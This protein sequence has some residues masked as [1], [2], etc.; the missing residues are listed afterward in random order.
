MQ[1]TTATTRAA[2]L[3]QAALDGWAT[4]VVPGW[5]VAH[6][7]VIAGPLG[8]AIVLT[9]DECADGPD[10]VAYAPEA[11]VD[12]YALWISDGTGVMRCRGCLYRRHPDLPGNWTHVHPDDSCPSHGILGD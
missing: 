3:V 6:G 1:I 8:V 2:A 12:G 7:D 4:I 9:D 5:A 11:P 10:V